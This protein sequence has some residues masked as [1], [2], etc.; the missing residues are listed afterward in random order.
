[1]PDPRALVNVLVN[2]IDATSAG[3]RVDVS[4]CVE[5]G[6]VRLAIRDSGVGIPPEDHERIFDMYFTTKGARGSGMG[7]ALAREVVHLHG[8]E[9]DLE[10]APG[11][12]STFTVVLPLA[13]TA[14]AESA[15]RTHEGSSLEEAR[16]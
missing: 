12:G 8:G 2:A 1:M 7:L 9:I 13:E 5:D 14:R 10:S 16:S 11:V 4:A 6:C 3:G 15:R